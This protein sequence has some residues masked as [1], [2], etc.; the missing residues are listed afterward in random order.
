MHGGR[1]TADSPG[2]GKGSSFN[3]YLPT[4]KVEDLPAPLPATLTFATSS[5]FKL[6]VVDDNVDAAQTL[7]ML[8]EMDG[9]PV[10]VSFDGLSTLQQFDG[11]AESPDIFILDIGLPD[12]DGT[13]LAQKLRELP[14]LEHTKMIAL[15]GYGQA[16]DK[17]RSLAAGFDYHLVKPVDYDHL[18]ALLAEI[19]A[20]LKALA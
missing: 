15:T 20:D 12:M 9:Y 10:S 8:L 2:I 11:D 14:H 17:A 4:A 13:E 1:V 18:K 19:E 7:A 5:S 3:V 16:S 6:H